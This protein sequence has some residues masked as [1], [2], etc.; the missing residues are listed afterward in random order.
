MDEQIRNNL[1]I[2][3]NIVET[4]KSDRHGNMPVCVTVK[5]QRFC[6]STGGSVNSLLFVVVAP[7]EPV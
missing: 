2:F 6:A 4:M 7:A 1:R 3:V 5:A